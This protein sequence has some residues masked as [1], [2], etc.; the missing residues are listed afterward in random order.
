MNSTVSLTSFKNVLVLIL[1]LFC[2][3]LTATPQT[4][5]SKAPRVRAISLRDVVRHANNYTPH[6]L[7]ISN[8]VLEDVRK[9]HETWSEYL[10]QL[11]DPRVDF[12]LGVKDKDG[13]SF[14]PHH[15]IICVDDL[16]K[17]L[18]ERKEKWVNHR[19]NV[20]LWIRD[21]AITTNIYVGYAVKIEFVDEKGKVVDTIVSSRFEG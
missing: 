5:R 19:I 4:R 14:D 6:T 13:S 7:K 11:Y 2:I 18:I 10:L 12:R 1:C 17:P 21:M 8:V 20:Y 3:S 16:G 15:F 9:L